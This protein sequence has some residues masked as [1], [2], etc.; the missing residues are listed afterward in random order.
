MHAH[1]DLFVVTKLRKNKLSAMSMPF[2]VADNLKNKAN[3]WSPRAFSLNCEPIVENHP[4]N[5]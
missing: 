2:F 5:I 1:I 4:E 3:I